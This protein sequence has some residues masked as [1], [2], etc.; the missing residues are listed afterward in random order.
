MNKPVA[1]LVTRLQGEGDGLIIGCLLK[2]G[3][4]ILKPNTVY[5]IRQNW[6]SRCI[7]LHEVGESCIGVSP[8][9]VRESHGQLHWALDLNDLLCSLYRR[10]MYLSKD[11][12]KELMLQNEDNES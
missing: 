4:G 1:R 7:E 10:H 9:T 5:E 6:L 11:E 8:Q 3:I 12:V 2:S